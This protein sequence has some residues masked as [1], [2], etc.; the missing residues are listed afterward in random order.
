MKID[1]PH[2]IR[3]DILVFIG[4]DIPH[5]VKKFVNALERSG[6]KYY[7]KFFFE[8]NIMSLKIL[9][10]VWKKSDGSRMGLIITNP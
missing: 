7:T 4:G 8:N 10:N 2:S 6:E 3:S 9:E 1:F 5:L